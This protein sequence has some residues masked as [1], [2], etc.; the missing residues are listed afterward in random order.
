MKIRCN[1]TETT[2]CEAHDPT[3]VENTRRRKIAEHADAQLCATGAITSGI[4]YLLMIAS[5]CSCHL[6]APC[7]YCIE[8]GTEDND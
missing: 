4:S 6:S 3:S 2:F 7:A 5:S 1:C 8:K